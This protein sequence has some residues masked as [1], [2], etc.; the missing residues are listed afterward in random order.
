[1]TRVGKL[2]EL[3][4]L[5]E[6]VPASEFQEEQKLTA[7]VTLE[8]G[9]VQAAYATVAPQ[10]RKADSISKRIQVAESA[11]RLGSADHLPLDGQITFFVKSEIP[12]RFSMRRR[13]KLPAPMVSSTP[14]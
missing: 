6:N 1:M 13:S 14:C 3:K 10:R 4:L 7:N 5:A 11:I 2:D 9:R 12:A 8:Q